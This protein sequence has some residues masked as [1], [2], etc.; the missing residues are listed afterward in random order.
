LA[1]CAE[2]DPE[3]S[4]ELEGIAAILRDHLEHNAREAEARR[5]L[6]AL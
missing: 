3:S 1:A 6:L 5:E 2:R 4:K